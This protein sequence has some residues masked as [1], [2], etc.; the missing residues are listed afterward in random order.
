MASSLLRPSSSPLP[1][2]CILLLLLL[3]SPPLSESSSSPSVLPSSLS[4]KKLCNSTPHPETC[5]KSLNLFVGINISP[6]ILTFLLQTLKSALSEASD[7]ARILGSAGAGVVENQRATLQ[8]CWELHQISLSCL[9]K[10][11]SFVLSGK[12]LSDVRT[13]LSAALTNRATCLEGLAAASGPAKETVAGAVAEAYKSVSNAL[14]ILSNVAPPPGAADGGDGTRRD[15]FT[16]NGYDPRSVL[17][18]AQDGSGNFTTIGDAVAAV[19]NNS[20][21]RTVIIVRAGVYNENVEIPS[22]KT[23]VVFLGDGSNA[24]VIRGSRSVGG[25]WTTFRSA[26]LGQ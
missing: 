7:L 20:G 9:R 15:D 26:T 5:L 14:S 22:Y 17:T 18:V 25:G 13:F 24:T 3:V 12:K 21:D 10:S 2:V 23:N 19:P 11:S 4:A 16:G 8:D 6:S 1:T